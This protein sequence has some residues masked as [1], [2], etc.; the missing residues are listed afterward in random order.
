MLSVMTTKNSTT[1]DACVY[2]WGEF[3]VHIRLNS[4]SV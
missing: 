2:G 1:R 3:L 4:V